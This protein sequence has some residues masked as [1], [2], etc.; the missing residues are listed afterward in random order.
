MSRGVLQLLPLDLGVELYEDGVIKRRGPPGTTG[1][2]CPRV[3]FRPP[4]L[5][6]RSA[7]TS[8]WRDVHCAL[9]VSELGDCCVRSSCWRCKRSMWCCRVLGARL[10]LTSGSSSVCHET[11]ALGS[12]LEAATASRWVSAVPRHPPDTL[13]SRTNTDPV[14]LVCRSAGDDDAAGRA[15][16]AA[17]NFVFIFLFCWKKVA[18]LRGC[19]T[20]IHE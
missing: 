6:V 8:L 5:T 17:S 3:V 15:A 7:D 20:P 19:R 11:A 10:S 1:S 2:S 12:A 9:A 14:D 16:A 4:R 13:L 18:C